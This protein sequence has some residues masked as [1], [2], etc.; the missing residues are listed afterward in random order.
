[1]LRS[2]IPLSLLALLMIIAFA[3]GSDGPDDRPVEPTVMAAEISGFLGE[4]NGCLRVRRHPNPGSKAPTTAIVWQKDVLAIERQ[5]DTV[6]IYAGE[7][8]DG[9]TPIASWR[10]GDEIRGGGGSISRQIADEHAGAG[11]SETCEGPYFLV[12]DVS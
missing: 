9:E 10:L 4:E 3:C 12:G 2:S 1:M 6:D 8:S 5:G 7:V 11:F